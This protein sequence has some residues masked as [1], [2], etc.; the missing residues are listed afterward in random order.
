MGEASSLGGARVLLGVTGSIAAYKAVELARLLVK[1]GARVQVAM[2]S[3]AARFVTPLTFRAIT[4]HPVLTD[5]FELGVRA[6][7][8]VDLGKRSDIEHVEAAHAIDLV[9]VAPATANSIARIAAGLAD[10]VLSAILL[11]TKAPILVAPAMETGMWEN[12]ATKDNVARLVSRGV[13][14]IGPEA[15]ELASGRSGMGR[16]AEPEAIVSAASA[17]LAPKDL[18][19][20][21]V[22]ITAGPTWEAIDPVRVLANRS[23]G[24]MGIEL[25]QAAAD[26]GADVALILGPTQLVPPSSPRVHTVRVESAVEMLEAGK[27]A[28]DHAAV[29]IASAAV[30]DFRPEEAKASKLKRSDKNARTLP[31]AEN[32]DVLLT[33]SKAMRSRARKNGPVVIVGFAAE[34]EDVE[35]NAREKLARKGC[36]LII[37]NRVGK[38]AG[39]GRDATEVVAVPIPERG[40]PK[41]FGP[42]SKREVA[43]FVLDQ[44]LWLRKKESG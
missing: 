12:A 11:A 22:V 2:S 42:A 1:A 43:Q 19:G 4:S 18:D 6:E 28:I 36:D 13:R 14:L 21:G 34:T 29:L 41:R 35:K 3:A 44:V 33:L 31:L 37:G 5:L 40:R 38:S 23:T 15:G 10:D 9:I 24:A 26:R 20:V 32:P 27:S 8:S 39:F 17:L 30:S 25:A 7:D 16:M